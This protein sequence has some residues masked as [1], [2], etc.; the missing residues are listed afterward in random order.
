MASR[1]YE[2]FVYIFYIF[3]FVDL[4]MVSSEPFG[5]GSGKAATRTR[6]GREFSGATKQE[7]SRPVHSFRSVRKSFVALF[8]SQSAQASCCVFQLSL[9][10]HSTHSH[11]EHG[12]LLRSLRR[13]EV[14]HPVRTGAV[15]SRESGPAAREEQSGSHRA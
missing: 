13:R 9:V 4:Q 5:P 6:R 12:R 14:R 10:A 7:H 15:L 3:S 11:S 8:F 2:G 1:R